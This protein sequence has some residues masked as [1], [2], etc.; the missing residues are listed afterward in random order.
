MNLE[1]L[2]PI[3]LPPAIRS[4][5]LPAA[6]GLGIAAL[7]YVGVS[8]VLAPAAGPAAAHAAVVEDLR[9]SEVV[10]RF[11]TAVLAGDAETAA[12]YTTAEFAED[13]IPMLSNGEAPAEAV[14]DK[15]ERYIAER[16]LVQVEIDR[17][18]P[19]DG[20]MRI[21]ATL[22]VFD[23]THFTAWADYYPEFTE[24]VDRAVALHARELS[25]SGADIDTTDRAANL[26]IIAGAGAEAFERVQDEISTITQSYVDEF[27]KAVG[28]DAEYMLEPVSTSSF[29]LERRSGRWLIVA[30]E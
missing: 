13:V 28:S 11:A 24:A 9:P 14:A 7:L 5:L 30:G 16:G 8:L 3:N 21:D 25:E 29:F 19:Q 4:L 17:M 26:L 1:R 15:I 27:F 23:A 18:A 12:K 10:R 22:H 6:L 20:R 2:I